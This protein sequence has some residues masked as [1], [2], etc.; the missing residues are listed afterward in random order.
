MEITRRE[1]IAVVGAAAACGCMS[2]CTQSS[3]QASMLP[4]GPIDAGPIGAFAADG[5]YTNSRDRNGFFVVRQGPRLFALSAICTHRAC[6]LDAES[7]KFT[8]PCHGSTFTLHGKVMRGPARRD[9]AI[10]AVERD[11]R[12]HLIVWTSKPVPFD[13]SDASIAFV[14][15]SHAVPDQHL[16]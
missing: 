5:V 15:M 12:E 7:E 14:E 8:C 11:A 4:T 9:L 6:K 3:G 16:I 1:W 2:G 10:F 13:A